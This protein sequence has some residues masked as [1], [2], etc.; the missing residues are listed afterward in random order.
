MV[1]MKSLIN[2]LKKFVYEEQSAQKLTL[3]FCIGCYIALSPFLFLHTVMV[4][5]A[6]WLFE[7]NLPVTLAA[8]AI[9]NPWTMV[10]VFM[11]DYLFGYWLV[12]NVM[13]IEYF[14]ASPNWMNNINDF[15]EMTLGITKPCLWS[16]MIGGNLLGILLSLALYPIMKKLFEK[17]ILEI[18]GPTT[19]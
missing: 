17:L 11:A 3:S 12:H 9:N 19:S 1:V 15:C 13:G 4:F 16:F 7:L 10:P 14:M 2:Y 18:H 6:V 5:I 8:A